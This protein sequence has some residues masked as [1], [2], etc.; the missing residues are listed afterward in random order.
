MKIYIAA[1]AK[2]RTDEVNKIQTKLRSMGHT[3]TY[4]WIIDDVNV[5]RPYRNPE[6]R[7]HNESTIPK[8][9]KAASEADVFI[10]LDEP[11]LRVAY[12]EL[13]AFLAD[14][15]KMP[16]NRRVYIVGMNSHEREHIFESPEY[17]RFAK[18]IDEVFKDL[19]NA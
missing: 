14:T 18:S 10:L 11:G 3:I 9:L 7:R 4:D 12:V 17:V 15:L 2:T 6:N 13:G 1:R 19:S 5:K 16:D 8:M